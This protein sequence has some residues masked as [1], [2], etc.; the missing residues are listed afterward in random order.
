V[1]WL[2]KSPARWRS[3]PSLVKPRSTR[4]VGYIDDLH[5]SARNE[6]LRRQQ[7]AIDHFDDGDCGMD[8]RRTCSDIPACA[9]GHS[10]TERW[11]E[12]LHAP[13]SDTISERYERPARPGELRNPGRTES[14]SADATQAATDLSGEPSIMVADARHDGRDHRRLCTQ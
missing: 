1:P 12:F 13:R 9:H 7:H 4:I 6:P 11:H 3:A 14:M 10:R 2:P 5:Y 8:A